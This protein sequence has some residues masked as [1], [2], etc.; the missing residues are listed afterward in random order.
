MSETAPTPSKVE[1]WINQYV[2]VRDQIKVVE[3]RHKAELADAKNIIEILTGKLQTAL[4][5]TG[6]ESIKTAEGTCYTST[7]Y[8][9]SLADP[10]AFM[11]FI[12]ANN[13]FDLLD[14]KANVTAV[15][16]YV[17]EH[18]TLPPGVSLSSIATVGVRRAPG[19]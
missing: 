15:K 4:T 17:T 3:D 13:L 10:K 7:R 11:D 1:K 12:I 16:D 9:A 5:A 14:R 19:K 8:T 2:A 6:A 18:N